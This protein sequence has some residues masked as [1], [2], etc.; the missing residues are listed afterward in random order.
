M[1]NFLETAPDFEVKKILSKNAVTAVTLL[2]PLSSKGYSGKQNC[3]PTVTPVTDFVTFVTSVTEK[4]TQKQYGNRV[5]KVTVKNNNKFFTSE[6]WLMMFEERASI[7][8]FEGGE[9]RTN[10]EEKAFDECILKLLDLDK[11]YT[12]QTAISHLMA[13][14]LHNPFYKKHLI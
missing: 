4:D 6:D 1:L 11:T 9:N 8:Q 5:T 2:Q 10:A 7:Y 3:Y 14:G 13:C 12:P